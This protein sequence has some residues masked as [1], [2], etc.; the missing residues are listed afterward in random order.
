MEYILILT[1]LNT[2]TK[3]ND[4]NSIPFKNEDSCVSAGEAWV[5]KVN[6]TFDYIISNNDR[7]FYLCVPSGN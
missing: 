2:N 4:I 3:I 5:K 6:S 1:L 7:S